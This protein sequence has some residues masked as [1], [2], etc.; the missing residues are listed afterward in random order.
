ML[1]DL[2]PRLLDN[3]SIAYIGLENIFARSLHSSRLLLVFCFGL[4][5]GMG[6]APVFPT[7]SYP[8]ALQCRDNNPYGS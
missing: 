5:H 8:G 4:L 2:L 7:T 6:F 1:A 3:L